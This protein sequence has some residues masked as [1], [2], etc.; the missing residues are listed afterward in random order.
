MII[1]NGQ[2]AKEFKKKKSLFKNEIIF[3]SGNAN[4]KN[5]KEIEFKREINLL[6]ST[7]KEY[8]KK[9]LFYFSTLDVL[10]KKKSKYIEHKKNIEKIL[11]KNKNAF[12]LRLP[13]VIGI[14]KNKFT[15]F[16]FLKFNVKKN[17]KIIV[18]Q[19][20]YRNFVDSNDI[21]LI[22]NKIKKNSKTNNIIN[23]FCKRSIKI[24]YLVDLMI[25]HY[26]LKNLKFKRNLVKD[27][28]Y[29]D[30]RKFKKGNFFAID[31]KNYYQNLL[32]KYL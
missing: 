24:S 15:V 32:K 19:N 22:V 5:K 7:L 28:F 4:S 21:P 6:K 10:R 12:I 17:I 16:N 11:K 14:S 13:Q 26:K 29:R 3:A 20:F 27:N 31:K 18:Y 1:G 2:I 30:M 9:K 25:A 8:K 23:I